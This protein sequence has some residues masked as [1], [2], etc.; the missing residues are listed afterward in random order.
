MPE[1]FQD[2]AAVQKP[3][4]SPGSEHAPS[5]LAVDANPRGDDSGPETTV[6]DSDEQKKGVLAFFK[7]KEFY[8]TLLLGQI[9]AITNTATGTFSTLLA[10]RGTS[11]PAFQTLLNYTLLNLIFTSYTLYRYG[12]KGWFQM[13]LKHGWKYIILA[14]CDVEGNYFVVLAYRYTTMLSAQLINFWAIAVVVVVSFLFLHVRYHVSQVLGILVCIGGMGVLIASDHITGTNGGE[15]PRGDQIKGDLFALLGATFYGLANTG[16]EY[17]VSTRPVY[18]VLG[19][20]AFF[21]MLINGTQAGIFDRESFRNAVWDGKAGGYLAGF[22]LCLTLFYCLVPLF[23]RLASAAFFNISLLT[24]N[25]WGVVIGVKVFHYTIHWMYPI[26]FVLIIVGQLIYYL[27]RRVLGEARKPW[28]GQN[29]EH[30]V[31]G[32]FTAK[33]KINY[34]TMSSDYPSDCGPILGSSSGVSV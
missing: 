14:F 22:T 34:Q 6:D 33:R 25:F 24:M 9:L 4:L 15:V 5:V 21:G 26:A 1:Y 18:E 17:F 30:G 31:A 2:Q 8:I 19:Q 10:D 20:M 28:L 13:V 3:L 7:T 12:I 29:Q 27:G 23:F 32:L 16:E 11:I